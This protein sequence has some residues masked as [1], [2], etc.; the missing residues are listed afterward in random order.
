MAMP[1]ATHRRW[2]VE[3]VRN[4]QDESRAWPR[5][6]L[7]D[8]ELYVTPAP[9][10]R[11][12]A[13]VAVLL[14]ILRPYVDANHLGGV[15]T[16]PAD[17]ELEPESV[18]QPDVFVFP[19]LDAEQPDWRSIT[20]LRLAIEVISPSSIRTDR[21]EKRDQYLKMAVDEYWVVDVEGGYVERWFKH[22]PDVEVA[23]STLVWHP[24][25][26][27]APLSIDVEAMFTA[28]RNYGGRKR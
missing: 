8:G 13:A 17:I 22:R 26:A 12:Q 20:S 9:G 19:P 10:F 18:L 11:H 27:A 15:L 23:R 25:H 3:E 24:A 7:I 16:S 28:I 21:R 2:K 6:E 1:V 5:Y 14:G 4:L